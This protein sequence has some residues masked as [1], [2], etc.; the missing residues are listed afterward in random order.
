[1]AAITHNIK[2][3]Q[4][5]TIIRQLPLYEADRTTPL[6][7]TSYSFR[8][9]L[10]NSETGSKIADFEC[11]AAVPTNGILTFGLPYTVTELLQPDARIYEYDIEIYTDTEVFRVVEGWAE[12]K[13]NVTQD[14]IPNEPSLIEQYSSTVQNMIE[15]A[16]PFTSVNAIWINELE[17]I[18]TN[19]TEYL[20]TH[21]LTDQNFISF[22]M[23]GTDY[24]SEFI[25]ELSFRI[26]DDYKSVR[27]TRAY[28]RISGTIAERVYTT[29]GV[30]SSNIDFNGQTPY[31][32]PLTGR[33]DF[34]ADGRVGVFVDGIQTSWTLLSSKLIAIDAVNAIVV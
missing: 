29:G 9:Y 26:P 12:F 16:N 14:L 10:R 34:W 22:F 11:S 18:V 3:E 13:K 8:G 33:A 20:F 23:G 19:I 25:I 6:D 21:N 30:D 32:Y 17:L 4:G 2:G 24:V 31:Q 27:K 15:T 5:A 1:M 7:L 28:V